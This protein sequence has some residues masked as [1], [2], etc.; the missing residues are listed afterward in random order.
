MI[1]GVLSACWFI[2][3]SQHLADSERTRLLFARREIADV[4]GKLTESE[5][6]I[7]TTV[8]LGVALERATSVERAALLDSFA[9]GFAGDCS[10]EDDG[11][12]FD[13]D[14]YRW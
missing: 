9:A 7:R 8:E 10:F 5:G 12:D 13:S 2:R 3:H 6:S 14:V 1:V 11:G 4:I